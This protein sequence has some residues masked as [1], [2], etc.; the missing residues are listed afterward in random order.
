MDKDHITPEASSCT[1]PPPSPFPSK[2]RRLDSET[3][4][5]D[6]SLAHATRHSTFWYDDGSIVLHAE[7]T[8]YRVHKSL[9]SLHSEVFADMLSVPQPIDEDQLEGC[10]IVRLHG[11]T[12]ADWQKLLIIL[13]NALYLESFQPPKDHTRTV[14]NFL[15]GLLRLATKYRFRAFREKSITILAALFPSALPSEIACKWKPS[16]A[17]E[18]I[19]IA[20]QVNILE[21]LPY[22]YLCLTDAL[23]DS[24]DI[25]KLPQLDWMDKAAALSGMVGVAQA[26]AE[27]MYPFVKGVDKAPGC[28][29]YT[30]NGIPCALQHLKRVRDQPHKTWW[31]YPMQWGQMGLCPLCE[32]PV[33]QTYYEGRKKVWDMLPK[34]FCLAESWD[35]L[36]RIQRYDGWV[37]TFVSSFSLY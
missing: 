22:A 9:L 31:F 17:I 18:L 11:D 19:Q 12:A 24:D 10:H 20:R 27:H 6:P 25:Y 32:A 26:Q 21:L 30:P 3:E 37:F 2:R 16:F 29:G 34:L 13:Y 28:S 8:L 23:K 15:P 35:D 7:N 33:R 1:S 36:V 14:M 5:E 4:A